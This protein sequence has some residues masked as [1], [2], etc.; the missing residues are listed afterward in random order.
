LRLCVDSAALFALLDREHIKHR[1]LADAWRQLAD[2]SDEV[3]A[4]SYT[5][6]EAAQMVHR[7]LPPTAVPAFFDELLA[8]VKVI[9]VDERLHEAAVA[10]MLVRPDKDLSLSD[11]VTYRVARQHHAI[12]VLALDDRF[13]FLGLTQIPG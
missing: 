5:V 2:G 1:S 3:L 4:H 11:W 8:P 12:A 10:A 7:R 6:A 9:W 13:K